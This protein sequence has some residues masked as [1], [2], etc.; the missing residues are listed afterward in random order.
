MTASAD[1]NCAS[2]TFSCANICAFDRRFVGFWLIATAEKTAIVAAAQSPLFYL[3][4][5]FVQSEK[6]Q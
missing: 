2:G 6:K 1:G 5:Q 3:F 4:A